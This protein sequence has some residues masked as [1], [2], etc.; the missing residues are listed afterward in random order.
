MNHT[1][2]IA[3]ILGGAA[4]V[5]YLLISRS[6]SASA[7]VPT[8]ATGLPLAPAPGAAAPPTA[9]SQV[10]SIAQSAPS[11]A[12]TLA[13]Y[14][15]TSA[16]AVVTGGLSTSTGRALYIGAGK[17]VVSGVTDAYHSIASIF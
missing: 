6:S 13:K 17:A 8:G 5:G 4:V 10:Q 16:L 3:L 9:L 2:K 1:V 14:G 15:A 12:T 11:T 7:L